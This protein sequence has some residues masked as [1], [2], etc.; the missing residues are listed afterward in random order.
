MSRT[1]IGG[2]SQN[3]TGLYDYADRCITI[4]PPM[5]DIRCSF[6]SL[7]LSGHWATRSGI[8]PWCFLDHLV[9]WQGRLDL[10]QRLHGSESFA[11]LTE[12]LP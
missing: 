4:P 5:R 6:R 7:F 12:L 2:V 1:R 10:P 3:R 9:N 11:L 8:L